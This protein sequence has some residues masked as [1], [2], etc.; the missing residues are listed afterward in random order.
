M[1]SRETLAANILMSFEKSM[2]APLRAD[3]ATPHRPRPAVFI[4]MSVAL[5]H[6]ACIRYL[7]EIPDRVSGGVGKRYRAFIQNYLPSAYKPHADVL[8]R[9]F[10]CGLIHEF[11]LKDI[12]L[13]D[14]DAREKHLKRVEGGALGLHAEPLLEA[15]VSAYERLRSEL[16]G[17]QADPELIKIFE[18]SGYKKWR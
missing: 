9:G 4:L 3:V 8:Y 6:L 7:G 15:I 17:P 11:Q 1:T 16:T 14:D 13:L 12:A 5:D 10:R 18:K 2:L